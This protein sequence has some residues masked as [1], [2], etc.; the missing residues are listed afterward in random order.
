MGLVKGG[1]RIVSVKQMSKP[2]YLS[3]G[4]IRNKFGNKIRGIIG[5][6]SGNGVMCV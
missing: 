6:F 4:Q 1:I 2:V 3:N 5:L